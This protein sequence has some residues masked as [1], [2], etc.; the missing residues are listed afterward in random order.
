MYG[1]CADSMRFVVQLQVCRSQ[2]GFHVLHILEITKAT[3]PVCCLQL[4]LQVCVRLALMCGCVTPAYFT[5]P[6]SP[7]GFPA[8]LS[9]VVP[10]GVR[11]AG[12]DVRLCDTSI[13]HSS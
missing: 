3:S 10:A 4:F 8:L 12:I 1:W 9:S 13:F 11:E 2:S 7:R 6:K 5:L